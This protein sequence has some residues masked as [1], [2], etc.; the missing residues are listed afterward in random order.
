MSLVFSRTDASKRVSRHYAVAVIVLGVLVIA[1]GILM[2][3]AQQQQAQILS[4]S[5][6]NAGQR[7]TFEE[8]GTLAQELMRQAGAETANLDLVSRMQRD[9]LAKTDKLRA[10]HEDI[11]ALAVQASLGEPDDTSLVSYFDSPPVALDSHFRAFVD[12]IESLATADPATISQHNR[13]WSALDLATAPNSALVQGF[14]QVVA[15]MHDRVTAT[16]DRIRTVSLLV[17]FSVLLVLGLEV[18][19]IFRPLVVRLRS[20]E[21]EAADANMR[22]AHLAHHDELTGLPNRRRLNQQIAALAL[23]GG[24]SAAALFLLDINGLKPINDTLGHRNGDE[25]LK[26]VARRLEAI[27]THGM[28]ARLGG[29]EFALLI[30]GDDIAA[31]PDAFAE[32]IAWAL[33]EPIQIEEETIRTGCSIGYATYPDQEIDPHQFLSAA[34]IALGE[35]KKKP[36][37]ARIAG[38]SKSTREHV[39]RDQILETELRKGLSRGEIVPYFQPQVFMDGGGHVGFEVLARWNHPRLGLLPASAWVPLAE[40]RGM[41][42]QLTKIMVAEST[43]LVEAWTKANLRPRLIAINVPHSVLAT[44][45]GLEDLLAAAAVLRTFDTGLEIEVTENVFLDRAADAIKENLSTAMQQGVRVALD[46]FGTGYASLKHLQEIPFSLLKIDQS[47]IR[48][49]EQRSSRALI[50]TILRLASDLGVNAIAE[51]IETPRHLD[52]LRQLGCTLGQGYLFGRPMPAADV[53]AYLA[54]LNHTATR[55]D[56]RRLSA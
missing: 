50:L 34:D 47:F 53:P 26:V 45:N 11:H 16:T 14:D 46:D 40:S 48:N 43:R 37:G 21:K 38:F 39:R 56:D 24:P 49:I 51:G 2:S 33:A 17:Q 13:L 10:N 7:L 9:L 27:A 15:A 54:S 25:M 18:L 1:G 23:P 30:P 32:R 44:R 8:I 28:A 6:K 4:L 29:D 20:E 31:K 22:L 19:V 36:R 42:T 41:I 5:Q 12:R 55:D 35:A 52:M 3:V